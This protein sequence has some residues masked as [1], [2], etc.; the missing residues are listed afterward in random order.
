MPEAYIYD[1]LRTPRGKGRPS[2]AL[3]SVSAVQLLA[4]ALINLR[5]RNQLDTA[6]VEDVIAGCGSPIIPLT[7]PLSP[8]MWARE[9][10]FD[11]DSY[12]SRV[13]P[14]QI[15]LLHPGSTGTIHWRGS[16]CGGS[17]AEDRPAG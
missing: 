1:H 5:D 15:L 13:Q 7:P 4:Q 6:L 3:H 16:V 10:D 2:G 17:G 9:Y 12:L 14:S 11:K 8:I